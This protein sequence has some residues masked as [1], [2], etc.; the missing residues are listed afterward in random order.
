V[1]VPAAKKEGPPDAPI[2]PGLKRWFHRYVETFHSDRPQIQINYD[3][4]REHTERVVREIV[5]LASALG[6]TEGETRLAEIIALLHDTGR[7]EQYRLFGTF[8]D[9]KSTDHAELSVKILVRKNVLAPLNERVRDVVFR[10]IRNHNRVSVPRTEGKKILFYS[11][12]LRD[13]DKLDIW[14]LVTDYY[15]I[16]NGR[17]N[18]SLELEL[19]DTPGISPAVE[20]SLRSGY[21][22]KIKD[23]KNLNDFK[24]IQ[25]GWVFDINFRPTWDRIRERRYIEKIRAAMPDT[26]QINRIFAGLYRAADVLGKK[27]ETSK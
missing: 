26:P 9:P 3:L 20:R 11:R 25:A 2:T 23:V 27:A 4:K 7:F 10:S 5:G 13:A 14:R 12:L 19:P 15:G 8:S 1:N 17:R 6:L 22:V 16:A 24:L 21:L 18:P